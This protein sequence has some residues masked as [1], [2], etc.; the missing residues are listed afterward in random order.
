MSGSIFKQKILI[1]VKTYP[2]LSNKYDELVCTAGITEEGNWIRIY[3]IPFRKIQEYNQY[4]KYDW[5]EI[6]LID[7]NSDP[8]P[9]S[10]R[11]YCNPVELEIVGNIDT[12]DN[13]R[14]RKDIVLKNV[15][16]DMK[17]LIQ[18]NKNDTGTSLA[19]FKPTEILAFTVEGTERNWDE[20]KLRI[21]EEK[22]KQLNL[23][24]EVAPF[25]IMPKIPY[26]FKFHFR[27]IN[28]VVSKMMIEDW[29]I[30]QLYLNCFYKYKDEKIACEKVREKYF[31]NF[32]KTKDLY[33]F[34]G[35]SRQYDGWA[36]N[37]FMI[38]G[39]FHPSVDERISLF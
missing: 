13:W 39:T 15:Y 18:D 38:I 30:G 32:S 12:R 8:R 25:K 22:G 37:P 20:K 16:D 5:V 28:G 27:D 7:N 2:T 11:P 10:Y 6:E 1:T 29:E 36:N 21:I 26:K 4:K 9:E 35:T 19:T 23:L 34:L 14:E 17:K 31:E 3:P 33:F 24:E